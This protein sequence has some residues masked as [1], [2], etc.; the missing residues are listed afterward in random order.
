MSHLLVCEFEG[1]GVLITFTGIIEP[2]EI[3]GLHQEI[4]SHP[5]FPRWCYQIW[6]FSQA[7]RLAFSTDDLRQFAAAERELA[8]I[9]PHQKLALIPRA[10]THKGLDNMFRVYESVW[11]VWESA[12]FWDVDS[13]R[14]WAKAGQYP[15]KNH[16]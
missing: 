12:T 1:M 14:E 6:D 8:K 4:S 16:F 13:A 11:G 10:S 9:N 15:E 3:F 2:D 7:E 5:D